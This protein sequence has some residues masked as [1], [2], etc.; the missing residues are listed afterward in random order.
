MPGVKLGEPCFI[1]LLFS[2]QA[3]VFVEEL[4]QFNACG[5]DFG[6]GAT[7]GGP[8]GI[9]LLPGGGDFPF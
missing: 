4:I 5:Q 3:C 2:E 1:M 9:E 7:V 8:E 6:V